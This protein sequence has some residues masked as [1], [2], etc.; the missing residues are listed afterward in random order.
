LAWHIQFYYREKGFAMKSP[1]ETI[2]T[3]SS[4]AVFG[5]AARGD[6]DQLSD[7]DILI[8]DEDI[9]VLRARAAFLKA[10]GWSVAS[11]TFKKLEA[12]ASQGALFIQHLKLESDI[13]IDRGTR[14]EALLSSYRPKASYAKELN[15][16][17]RLA[18]LLSIIGKGSMSEMWAADLLYVTVRNFGVLKLAGSGIHVYSFDRILHELVSSH[19]ISNSVV[20]ELRKLRFMKCLYRSG[21]AVASG[22]VLRTVRA[23]LAGLPCE[24]FP[25]NVELVGGDYILLSPPPSAGEAAYL[26][27]R[28]LEKRLITAQFLNGGPVADLE[29]QALQRWVADPRIYANLS[30]AMAPVLREKIGTYAGRSMENVACSLKFCAKKN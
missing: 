15:A 2:C 7:R 13:L 30:A 18:N 20:Q 10:E 24:A 14:L 1:S 4:E 12:L 22:R 23:S 16:N 9:H 27:L 8:V 29:L 6:S 25:Q 17:F 28:D 5:S 3:A 26:V 11:Y 19:V 21:E